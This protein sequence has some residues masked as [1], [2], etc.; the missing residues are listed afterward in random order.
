MNK[1]KRLSILLIVCGLSGAWKTNFKL[2]SKFAGDG[3]DKFPAGEK[4]YAYLFC[5]NGVDADAAQKGKADWRRST[6]HDYCWNEHRGSDDTWK[7]GWE[8]SRLM[9]GCKS[10]LNFFGNKVYRCYDITRDPEFALI[11]AD[12]TAEKKQAYDDWLAI[13]NAKVDEL[14]KGANQS[15]G[16]IDIELKL[17]QEKEARAKA[18]KARMEQ[19]A[20]LAKRNIDDLATRHA[21]MEKLLGALVDQFD[22]GWNTLLSKSEKLSS[23]MDAT[24]SSM[25]TF[26]SRI[27]ASNQS[28]VSLSAIQ[29]E[30]AASLEESQAQ[31]CKGLDTGRD[32]EN[33]RSLAAYMNRLIDPAVVDAEAIHIPGSFLEAREGMLSKIRG[34]YSVSEKREFIFDSSYDVLSEEPAVCEDI[35]VLLT[36]LGKAVGYAKRAEEIKKT[37]GV[38]A[39]FEAALK[40]I[41]AEYEASAQYNAAILRARDIEA[42]WVEHLTTGEVVKGR[43]LLEN[44]DQS[45]A[46]IMSVPAL[47]SSTVDLKKLSAQLDSYKARIREEAA[48]R[49]SLNGAHGMLFKRLGR[50][51]TAIM[52]LEIKSR[53]KPQLN[54]VWS[55]QKQDIFATLNTKPGKDIESQV[56]SE[57]SPLLEYEQM[58]DRMEATL[59]QLLIQNP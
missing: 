14:Y 31:L 53:Q 23:D 13:Y 36:K 18:E 41:D 3:S 46:R 25:A 44:L 35:N 49:I 28:H 59:D 57:W 33:L 34:L 50:I 4:D 43:A 55:L 2:T 32:V 51:K 39:D 20:A 10:Q 26:R 56:F 15:F 9:R 17:S 30:A 6:S 40:K 52:K 27:K 45:F 47:L 16:D 19:E 22:K 12:L 8:R 38:I 11:E 37:I 48:Y 29:T 1:C 54:S 24:N 21:E 5:E 42:K 58:L 7:S